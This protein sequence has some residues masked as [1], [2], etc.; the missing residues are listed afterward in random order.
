M[1]T[2][3]GFVSNSS[4]SSF[5]V[6]FD[7]AKFVKCAHCGHTPTDPVKLVEQLEDG[8]SEVRWRNVVDRVVKL[9]EEIAEHKS[10][11]DNLSRRNPEERYDRYGDYT[12]EQQI[13][14]SQYDIGELEKEIGD[15][16]KM[17]SEYP[18]KTIAGIEVSY[19]NEA[20]T[21]LLEEMHES[22][23]IIKKGEE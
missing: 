10:H 15:L 14:Y 16:R 6:I 7:P 3:S 13:Q 1:K 5:I 2:R 9:E 11:I 17:Q 23:L 18:G 4:S 12:V 21:R 20:V 19:H 22:G 8:D